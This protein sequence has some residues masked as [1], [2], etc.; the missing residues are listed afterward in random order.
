MAVALGVILYTSSCTKKYICH[1]DVKYTGV[2]GL[3]DS[4]SKEFDI[5]DTKSN[6]KSKCES[7]SKTF[8]NGGIHTVET[9]YLY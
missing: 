4:S 8:D 2:P 1:C 9:C 6:A 5:T 7:E 3:P